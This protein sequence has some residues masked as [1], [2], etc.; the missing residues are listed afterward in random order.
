MIIWQ[1]VSFWAFIITMLGLII[2]WLASHKIANNH[3]VHID[4]KLDK[5]DSKVDKITDKINEHDKDI[6][7][8]QEKSKTRIRKRKIK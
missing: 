8:L 5:I 6:A 2:N 1:D 4:E 3:L 7:V